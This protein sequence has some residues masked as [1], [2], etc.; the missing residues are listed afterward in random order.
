MPTWYRYGMEAGLH[1]LTGQIE[2][3]T[4]IGDAMQNAALGKI[5]VD[6][7]VDADRRAA[8]LP[9]R[10]ADAMTRRTGDR[11]GVIMDAAAV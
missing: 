1:P 8:A 6:A 5:T 2:A 10:N 7:A 4:F 9:G 3:T 11:G